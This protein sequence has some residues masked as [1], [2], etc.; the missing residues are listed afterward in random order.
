MNLIMNVVTQGEVGLWI[1]GKQMYDMLNTI[2]YMPCMFQYI[3]LCDPFQ[4]KLLDE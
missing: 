1:N 2:C 3:C 4:Y